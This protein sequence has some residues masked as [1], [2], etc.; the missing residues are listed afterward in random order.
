MTQGGAKQLRLSE[1]T[2][3]CADK[4]V[5]EWQH[6]FSDLPLE[7]NELDEIGPERSS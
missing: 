6:W 3:D 7:L 2:A 5:I 4:V 1:R